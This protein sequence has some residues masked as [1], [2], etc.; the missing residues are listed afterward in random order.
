MKAEGLGAGWGKEGR[1]AE[2]R[3][4]ISAGVSNGRRKETRASWMAPVSG[5]VLVVV[6]VG[7]QNE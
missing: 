4:V 6:P 5:V 2:W 7:T 3:A 1:S